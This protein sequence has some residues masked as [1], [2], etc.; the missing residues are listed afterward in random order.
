MVQLS[1][2][3]AFCF[4][5]AAMAS[6]M[7]EVAKRGKSVP[8]SITS[9]EYEGEG[10]PAGSLTGSLDPNT[11]EFD[12]F[13]RELDASIK[14]G[15]DK[16]KVKCHIEVGLQTSADTQLVVISG[17]YRGHVRLTKGGWAKNQNQYK[18]KNNPGTTDMEWVFKGPT[19]VSTAFTN[20][21][22]T[23]F[24][25]GCGSDGGAYTLI[26]N[27]YLTMTTEGSGEG[28]ISIQELDGAIKQSVKLSTEDC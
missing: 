18:F 13:Y 15:D 23:T 8:I 22:A 27:N 5:G 9:L 26:I 1:S 3:L 19:D 16:V 24:K 28:E 10:C 2:V 25:S 11:G 12:V 17:T 6:P 4:A 14:P 20:E 21:L 7:V